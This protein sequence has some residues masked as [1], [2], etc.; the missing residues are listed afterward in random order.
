MTQKEMTQKEIVTEIPTIRA[1]SLCSLLCNYFH[2]FL[3]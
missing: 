2:F 1:C 3:P